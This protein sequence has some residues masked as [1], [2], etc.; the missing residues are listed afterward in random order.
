M[1]EAVTNLL[2]PQTAVLKERITESADTFSLY[3]SAAN[4]KNFSYKPGQFNML[5]IAGIGEAPFS[6]SSLDTGKREFV[7]TIRT[8]GN[9]VDALSKFRKGQKITF[10]G[11]YGTGWPMDKLKGKNVI[12]V[13]GGIGIA[14]LRPVIHYLIKNK[15]IPASIYLIYGTKTLTDILFKNEL[16]KWS[17]DINV[18]LSAEAINGKSSLD[19]QKGLVTILLSRIKVSPAESITLMCGPQIMMKFVAADLILKGQKSSDIYISL[20]RRMRCGISHCGHCQI[21]AKYVCKD[22]PVFCLPDIK[23]FPDTLI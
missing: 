18:L 6:F 3:L 4:A 13:A 17:K 15:S 11:P 22:G 16:K 5:G 9:V 7:H 20:E 2:L 12:V 19:I 8:A 1:K 10:R 21:G 14:P 23:R